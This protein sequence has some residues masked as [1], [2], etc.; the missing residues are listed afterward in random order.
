VARAKR[1]YVRG[2][3]WHIT[4]RCHKREFLLKFT[5]DRRRW[6]ELLLE[7]TRRYGL[8][9][10][11]YMVTS[12]HIH[13]LVYDSSGREV[14]PRSMQLVA[15]RSGQEYNERKRRR[16]AFWQDRYHATAV[17]D[18]EHLLRCI[19]YLDLNMV[20]AGVVHHPSAWPFS[21][22][23]EIQQP[24]RKCAV[25]A[26]DKLRE[27]CGFSAYDGLRTAHREWLEASLKDGG[28]VR[29]A[30]WTE[31]IAVGSEEFTERIKER[32]GVRAK[33]REVFAGGD[34]F[35]LR[36]REPGYGDDSCLENDDI[37]LENEYFW[38]VFP[39]RL[40]G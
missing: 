34:V 3:I 18:G 19:V 17:E 28:G 4:H 37:G 26:Y 29:E 20:R 30:E 24:R 22:Y 8:V 16:G 15:G 40:E 32:L 5:R 31:S 12:N 13:L 21:G 14:I 38:N 25:V 39:A 36:E 23:R 9:A 1:H 7:A 10:L 6:I 11:N 35:H 33:G 2:Q 27:L